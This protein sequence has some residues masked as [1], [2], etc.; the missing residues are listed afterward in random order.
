MTSLQILQGHMILR[1][2]KLDH[3][4][5]NVIVGRAS[6]DY[7][8]NKIFA[9]FCPFYRNNYPYNASHADYQETSFGNSFP[10]MTPPCTPGRH[11]HK[12]R[13]N[14][15]RRRSSGPSSCTIR[16]VKSN[17]HKTYRQFQRCQKQS[18]PA[19][20]YIYHSPSSA[21]FTIVEC[22]VFASLIGETP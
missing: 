12:P 17:G 9:A 7:I 3:N 8:V 2:T 1:H 20:Y 14:R 6:G 5:Q 16:F 13:Q 18:H 4:E 21:S 10:L 19:F 15:D 22:S 11:P